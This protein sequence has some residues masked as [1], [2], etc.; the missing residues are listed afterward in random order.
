MKVLFFCF[1]LVS[2]VAFSHGKA[3]DE[4]KNTETNGKSSERKVSD[5]EIDNE[6]EV[7]NP[8]NRGCSPITRC[9]GIITIVL[10]EDSHGKAK[11]EMKNTETNGKSSE[12]KV[13]DAEIDNEHEVA[14]PY[15]RGCSPITRCRGGGGHGAH[16]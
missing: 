2:M 4:M 12:R 16:I 11:D 5:A 8:Y 14:N 13:S 7:A 9:R 10:V 1:L 3:E 15:N 6:H